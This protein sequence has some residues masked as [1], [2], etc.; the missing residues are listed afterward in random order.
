MCS[1]PLSK[2][3]ES[4]RQAPLHSQ[5]CFLFSFPSFSLFIL[6]VGRH[7]PAQPGANNRGGQS[8]AERAVSARTCNQSLTVA[9]RRCP[10]CGA[11]RARSHAI[12]SPPDRCPSRALSLPSFSSSMQR[13]SSLT[14]TRPTAALAAP[15]QGEIGRHGNP[16]QLRSFISVP[17]PVWLSM[18][19]SNAPTNCQFGSP[20]IQH[21]KCLG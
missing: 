6:Y 18:M 17:Q 10:R 9:W 19:Q 8:Q 2:S 4:A 7:R 13:D 3:N 5:S 15:S 1:Y 20:S 14:P 12:T 11:G 21:A 16:V